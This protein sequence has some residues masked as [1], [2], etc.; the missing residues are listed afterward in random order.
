MIAGLVRGLE[1]AGHA[2]GFYSN[3]SGWQTITGTWWTPGIP[4]WVTVGPRTSADAAAACARASFS[5][6]APHLAQWWDSTR[7]YDQ[8]CAAYSAAPAVPYPPS[9]PNDLN[10]DWTIDL[11]A[12]ERSTGA[13]WLYPRTSSRVRAGIG[14]QG[15]EVIDTAGDLTG[16]GVPD[17]LSRSG[18]LLWLY[19]R[20]GTG[21]WLPR[22]SL[23][24]GW[25]A[26][27]A[28]LGV[29]DIDGDRIPDVLARERT[30]G[31]LWLYGGTGAAGFASRVRVG[32]GWNG[33]DVLLGPGYVDGDGIVDVLARDPATGTLWIYPTDGGGHWRARISMGRGWNAMDVLT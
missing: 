11:L 27:S 29:G 10:G 8:T 24:S 21:G 32:T 17:V 23:G 22:R 13:L 4:A 2:Y 14:W 5:A 16:D 25:A 15:L 6:G 33:F 28:V 1:E 31:A 30:T 18:D 19:P 12:R 20:S 26:M 7:D 3:T 9:G